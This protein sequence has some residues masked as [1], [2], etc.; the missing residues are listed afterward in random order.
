VAAGVESVLF[1]GPAGQ[2]WQVP[3]TG[4]KWRPARSVGVAAG[5]SSA[6]FAASGGTTGPLE[7]FWVGPKATLWSARFTTS[8]GWQQPVDLGVLVQRRG[9]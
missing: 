6:P 9:R 8:T 1:R 7:L 2:L 4:G 3:R 5:L